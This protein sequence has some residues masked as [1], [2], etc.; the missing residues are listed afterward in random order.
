MNRTFAHGDGAYT[1]NGFPPD[2]VSVELQNK[3]QTQDAQKMVDFVKSTDPN[4]LRGSGR[5][6]Q[7][8]L[9]NFSGHAEKQSIRYRK[10]NGLDY[11]TTGITRPMCG[12]C[13]SFF[14]RVSAQGQTTLFAADPENVTMF[15]PGSASNNA[16]H[17][18][19]N[20]TPK[21]KINY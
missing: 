5:Y 14:D 1:V 18:R 21:G 16:I 7:S 3:I 8:P 15:V 20:W 11:H 6:Y 9:D 17:F 19:I 10:V 12:N 4:L 2:R 13:V